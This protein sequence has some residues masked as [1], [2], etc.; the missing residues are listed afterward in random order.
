[1]LGLWKSR[2]CEAKSVESSLVSLL[3]SS[4]LSCKIGGVSHAITDQPVQTCVQLHLH[5]HQHHWGSV[6]RRKLNDVGSN[7][8][9]R[10]HLPYHLLVFNGVKK[11]SSGIVSRLLPVFHE[12]DNK[13]R[14]IM[15]LEDL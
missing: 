11:C 4:L 9:P 10:N 8:F 6:E 13:E 15:V 12:Y 5:R 1:M 3:S 2:V 14:F 7:K